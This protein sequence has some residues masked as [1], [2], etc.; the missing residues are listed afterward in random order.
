[1]EDQWNDRRRRQRLSFR[2]DETEDR[3]DDFTR[4]YQA[5]TRE[6]SLFFYFAGIALPI[7]WYAMHQ[8][9]G[10]FAYRTDIGWLVFVVSGLITVSIA[11][12]T[13]SFQAVKAALTNPV[14][15]LKSE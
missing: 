5:E 14:K 11:F 9:L 8:W 1:M 10:G 13:I 7:A 3:P 15:S 2:V 6:A 12:L 4:L